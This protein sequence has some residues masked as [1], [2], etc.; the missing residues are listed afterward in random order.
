[1]RFMT[2]KDRA[3]LHIPAPNDRSDGFVVSE[4]KTSLKATLRLAT[5]SI[6]ASD[7]YTWMQVLHQTHRLLCGQR[8]SL[9]V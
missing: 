9:S 7:E 4:A 1:M 3:E 2:T 5:R 8:Q 6:G